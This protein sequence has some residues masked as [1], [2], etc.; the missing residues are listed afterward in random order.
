MHKDEHKIRERTIEDIEKKTGVLEMPTHLVSTVD[1]IK[2]MM[3]MNT[4][5]CR[6][7]YFDYMNSDNMECTVGART[8][9]HC[10]YFSQ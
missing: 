10:N 9:N 3:A 5:D 6:R 1:L 7:I 8:E 4:N 2:I